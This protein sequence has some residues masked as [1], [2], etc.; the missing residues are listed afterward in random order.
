MTFERAGRE[1]GSGTGVGEG[2]GAV[3][4]VVCTEE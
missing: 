2:V 4:V 1:T 3:E